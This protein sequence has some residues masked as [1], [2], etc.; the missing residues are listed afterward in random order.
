MFLEQTRPVYNYQISVQQISV[1]AGEQHGLDRV[2][3]QYV[4]LWN[5]DVGLSSGTE[6]AL[7]SNWPEELSQQASK[8]SVHDVRT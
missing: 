2:V 5:N 7:Y 1:A 6:V 8:Q 3:G 4:A